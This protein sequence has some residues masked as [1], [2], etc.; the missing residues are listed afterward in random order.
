MYDGS[1]MTRGLNNLDNQLP[2]TH[3]NVDLAV[4]ARLLT[5]GSSNICTMANVDMVF[6]ELECALVIWI[7]PSANSYDILIS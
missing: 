1:Y 4:S 2:G 6:G 7:M 5:A 3:V